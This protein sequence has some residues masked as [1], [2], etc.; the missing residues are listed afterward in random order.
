MSTYEDSGVSIERGDKFTERIR[1]IASSAMDKDIGGFAAGYELDLKRWSRPVLFS[2]TDG[3]G[4]KLLVAQKLGKFDTIGIDLVAM[5]ANDILVCGAEP[6]HFLDYIACGKLDENKMASI[7]EGIAKGC[8]QAGCTLSGG[9][10]AEM[11][12]VYAEDDFDLAGFCIGIAEKENILPL[13]DKIK[14]G[15]LLFGIPSTGIHS[16]GLSLAR[17]ALADSKTDVW[18]RLLTPTRIYTDAL[19][20][21]FGSSS[22]LAAAHITGGGLAGNIQRVLPEKLKP[23]LYYNWDIPEIFSRIQKDG[24]VEKE[25]MYRVFNM[26]LGMVLI[27]NKEKAD[28]FTS[29]AE[30]QHVDIKEVGRVRNG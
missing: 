7:V 12:D 20:P 26:G 23:E 19:K 9:E 2:G 24:K 3:V 10:T 15:D 22:L 28:A 13:K 14:E 6:V 5:C 16:N 27:I 1:S 21:F 4:T 30:Q 8:E 29:L 11:P 25:E 18:E 17:K